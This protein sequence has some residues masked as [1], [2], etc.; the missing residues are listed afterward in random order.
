VSYA[1]VVVIALAVGAVV[2]AVTLRLSIP[3]DTSSFDP[4][5]P[6]TG[7]EPLRAP[8]VTYVPVSVGAPVSWRSRSISLLALVALIMVCATAIAVALYQVGWIIVR[9]IIHKLQTS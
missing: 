4:E 7:G 9:V 6:V 8:G 2:Y 5:G 1:I 3:P